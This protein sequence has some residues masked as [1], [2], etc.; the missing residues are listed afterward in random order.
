MKFDTKNKRQKKKS[1]L[2]VFDVLDIFTKSGVIKA[3]MDEILMDFNKA[4]YEN[5]HTEGVATQ[6]FVN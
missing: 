4:D 6:L 5:Q 1:F 3:R 2:F